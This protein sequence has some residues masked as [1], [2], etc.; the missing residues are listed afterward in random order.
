MST[1]KKATSPF[2]DECHALADDYWIE[3]L[4]DGT[5]VLIRPLQ[6]KDREREF[7]FVSHLARSGR[8]RFMG[9]FSPAQASLLDQLMDIDYRNRMAYV[10][11]VHENGQLIE[12]GV[13]RYG[14]FEGDHHCEFAVAV[15]EGWRRRGLGRLLMGHLID[16]ARRHGFDSM[17]AMDTS[18]NE[19]MRDMA[20]KYG[21]ECHADKQDAS[22]II[23]KYALGDKDEAG[24]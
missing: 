1:I 24:Y 9:S 16:S 10:A 19:L 7:A 13:S 22:Q 15:A 14:A 11:L 18:S 3:S 2:T 5:H 12:I 20:R 4:N 17:A 21:F 6:P 8:F 23:Y